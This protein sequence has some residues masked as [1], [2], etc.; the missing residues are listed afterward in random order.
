MQTK[1]SAALLVA[2]LAVAGIVFSLVLTPYETIRIRNSS[3]LE[4]DGLNATVY[5]PQGKGPFPA[6]VLLHGCAGI[7]EKHH[8]WA[9]ELVDW[10]YVALILDSFSPRSVTRLCEADDPA[11]TRF[12]QLRPHDAYAALNYLQSLSQVD[13]ERVGLLGWSFGGTI[14]LWALEE[15]AYANEA[16]IGFGA[17]VIIYPGCWQF[18][19][20]KIE[21]DSYSSTAPLLILQ[22]TADD[23]TRAENCQKLVTLA[24]N[25]AHP[26]DLRLYPG[27][28]HDFDNRTQRSVKLHGV[29]IEA[30]EASGTVT[31]GYNQAA[32]DG[33][34]ADTRH[35]F[36]RYLMYK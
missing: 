22:G 14:A 33:A 9:K 25:S 3:V 2:M 26:V 1:R 35:F 13:A 23:W 8:D 28:F 6:V 29:R 15:G 4:A 21:K 18:L 32:H 7:M 17:G 27:A 12:Q 31:V 20:S 10:G 5:A 11:W 30:P 34:L 24:G 16:D 19:Q 36:Q